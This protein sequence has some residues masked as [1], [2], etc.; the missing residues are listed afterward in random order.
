MS[1][2]V[3]LKRV[4]S[5]VL[6][7]TFFN[8]VI[9]CIIVEK[10]P[11]V[12]TNEQ[13]GKIIFDEIGKIESSIHPFVISMHPHKK[14]DTKGGKMLNIG[15]KHSTTIKKN[16]MIAPTLKIAWFDDKMTS[17]KSTLFFISFL[18][19]KTSSFTLIFL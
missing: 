11:K 9:D 5:E 18:V 14:E 10:P 15:L 17:L 1:A 6:S 12:M 19:F 13:I 7:F 8:N 2:C 4:K 3:N 16:I